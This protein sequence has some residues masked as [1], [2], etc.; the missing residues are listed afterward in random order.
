MTEI[1]RSLESTERNAELLCHVFV[2]H[3]L[4]IA[5]DDGLGELDGKSVDGVTEPAGQILLFESAMRVRGCICVF[6]KTHGVF[7][8]FAVG[9]ER[10][11]PASAPI[12]IDRVVACHSLNP[13]R[14]ASRAV[15]TL[16]RGEEVQEDLLS[17]LFCFVRSSGELVRHM[18]NPPLI[19]LDEHCP[20]TL[21]ALRAATSQLG[22][23]YQLAWSPL[24]LSNSDPET[25]FVHGMFHRCVPLSQRLG[26]VFE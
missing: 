16:E 13:C 26:S 10:A 2:A 15:E 24:F 11:L 18:P 1:V 6:G 14:Q 19:S 20:G 25:H 5:K 12:V 3:L 4:K 9:D 7:E 21:V 8:L 23:L 17:K 22:F